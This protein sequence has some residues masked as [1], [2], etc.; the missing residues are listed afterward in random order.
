M[1]KTGLF[2][3]I[4]VTTSAPLLAKEGVLMVFFTSW[5]HIF[6]LTKGESQEGLD[7][8]VYADYKVPI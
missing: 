1:W 5:S 6:P 3:A 8:K 4:F 7:L 2:R